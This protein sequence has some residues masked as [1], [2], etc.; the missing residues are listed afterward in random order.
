MKF[1]HF[2]GSCEPA[3]A[4][5]EA[6]YK[7]KAEIIPSPFDWLG[8]PT[9][10]LADLILLENWCEEVFK[11][12]NLVLYRP[13][14]P[15]YI[16]VRDIKYN[17]NAVHHFMREG[18]KNF[19]EII[20]KKLPDF[21]NKMVSR[22]NNF[23]EILNKNSEIFIFIR[24]YN[25]TYFAGKKSKEEAIQSA[26]NAIINFAPNANL[27]MVCD[28]QPQIFDKAIVLMQK[29]HNKERFNQTSDWYDCWEFFIKNNLEKGRLYTSNFFPTTKPKRISR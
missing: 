1:I 15:E 25:P 20:N 3:F 17:I 19:H 7:T 9:E 14:Q 11:L 21:K 8:V 2:G 26:Y 18:N 27:V 10:V 28:N 24:E 29:K 4:F 16:G 12:E 13:Q 5:L 23:L 22:W 6:S